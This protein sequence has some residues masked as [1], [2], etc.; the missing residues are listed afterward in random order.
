RLEAAHRA[1]IEE[2]D[3]SSLPYVVGHFP[4]LEL[5][6]G[7]WS[8]AERRA[9]E[10]LELA[11]GTAQPDQRR[12]AL[13][14][15]SLVHAHM[16]REEEARAEAEELR[17]AAEEAG[18]QWGDSNAEAVL[19]LLE[20]SLGNPADAA[21]HLAR[22]M[23]IREGIGTTE[24]IRAYAD[25]AEA[26]IEL[27]ELDR[28][29]EV[30]NLL[31]ERARAAHRTPLLAVAACSRGLLAA[32]RQDLD[33]AVAALDDALAHHERVRVPFDLARTLLAVG[34]VRRRRGERKA[35]REALERARG[36]FEELG[37]PLW[38]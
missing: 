38:F 36:I 17:F 37:A 30:I 32:A 23:E 11:E 18:E 34:Q 7:N 29:E 24:P 25:Y 13:F 3:E 16:G 33:S 19:G 26:L 10:H 20:L 2:G 35:A 14:N 22:T 12:Q 8:E 28:A 4:Q 15:R 27:G 31:E 6:T 9:L 5:W 21:R 1:A